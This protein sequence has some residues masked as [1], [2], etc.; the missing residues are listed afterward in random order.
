[1]SEQISFDPRVAYQNI[2]DAL[3]DTTS[4]LSSRLINEDR[5]YT[6]GLRDERE[7]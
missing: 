5:I 1:M 3:V 2:I 7:S 6:K 4:S